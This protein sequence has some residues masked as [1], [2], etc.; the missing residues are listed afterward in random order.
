MNATAKRRVAALEQ[1][2]ETVDRPPYFVVD[3]E[4]QITDEMRAA[5]VKIYVGISPDSWDENNEPESES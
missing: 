4:S 3:D 1:H 2:S 5:N